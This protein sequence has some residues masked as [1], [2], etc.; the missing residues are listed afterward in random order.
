MYALYSL[1]HPRRL[2]RIHDNEVKTQSEDIFTMDEL[3][4]SI[5]QIIWQELYDKENINSYKRELQKMQIN[6]YS[7]MIYSNFEFSSDAVALARYS[8]KNILKEIYL[9]LSNNKLDNYTKSHLQN[10]SEMIET[11][12]SAEIQIN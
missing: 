3:F 4:N 10:S 8:L 11:I 6:M 7:K 5:N 2:A 12:L 9:H 1:F